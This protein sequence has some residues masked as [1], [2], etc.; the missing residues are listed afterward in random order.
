[1]T[2][3]MSMLKILEEMK[4]KNEDVYVIYEKTS[5]IFTNELVSKD[6]FYIVD[7]PTN[8]LWVNKE[9]VHHIN[10]NKNKLNYKI[11][12]N[13]PSIIQGGIV[14]VD[15]KF[16]KVGIKDVKE[17]KMFFYIFP[18]S[19]LRGVKIGYQGF[20]KHKEEE[21][22]KEVEVMEIGEI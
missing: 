8:Q 1:M 17:G 18:T 7:T 2:S 20:E 11:V 19:K 6:N 14:D 9:D 5:I 16:V 13:L 15:D 3:P 22:C 4:G 10:Y 12:F 21:I